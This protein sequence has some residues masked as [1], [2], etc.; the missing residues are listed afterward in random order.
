MSRRLVF[1]HR[2]ASGS[3]FEN[4]LSAFSA[5]VQQRADGIELDVQVTADGIP[6]VVHDED[7]VR[8]AGIRRKVSDMYASELQNIRVGKRFIRSLFG[9]PIPTLRESISFCAINQLALNIEL[10]AS[11][12]ENCSIL[13]EIID[14]AG[15]L[16]NVHISSF[17]ETL[18][19][20]IKTLHPQME[21]AL[22]LRKKTTDW[23]S[24]HRYT[25]A[26]GFHFHKRLYKE[27]YL[28]KLEASGKRLRVYGVTG[29]EPFV[30]SPSAA[31]VGWITDF[32]QR[33]S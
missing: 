32:P 2:G 17:D 26:D 16:N 20:Q 4:T 33:F 10:K 30:Q 29:N 12:A 1:A 28:S 18:I 22:L 23:D 8:V 21:T 27:P 7:L 15:L 19:Q 25:F 11:V 6:V 13:E 24:L 9:H 14:M 3:R 31:V 5:A